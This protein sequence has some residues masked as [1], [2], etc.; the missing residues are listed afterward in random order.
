MDPAALQQCLPGCRAFEPVGPD[1]WEATMTIGLAAIKG[2]YSGRIRIT[3]QQPETSY[4]LAVQG[5]G[6][7][8]RIRGEGQI[9]LSDAAD[10]GTLVRYEGDAQVQ[11]PLAP[12]GQ[13][14]LPP[15]A[16]MLADQF[17]RCMGTQIK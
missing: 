13:R 4:R 14:L 7:G 1:E 12:V 5:Q 11:G 8:N 17:F 3:D 15:A 9:T 16:K 2:T 10:G 6:A